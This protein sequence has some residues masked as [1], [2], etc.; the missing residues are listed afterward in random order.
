MHLQQLYW[1]SLHFLLFFPPSSWRINIFKPT[2][3]SSLISVMLS[4][5]VLCLLRLSI[6]RVKYSAEQSRDEPIQRE[7]GVFT[8]IN[9][10]GEADSGCLVDDE[11]SNPHLRLSTIELLSH[12]GIFH[13]IFH[14][15]RKACLSAT[16]LCLRGGECHWWPAPLS[17]V[18]Q[19]KRKC[20]FMCS[21]HLFGGKHL[22]AA[23]SELACHFQ[24]YKLPQRSL[25]QMC[26][27][28]REW[29]LNRRNTTR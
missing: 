20:L 19:T 5:P 23:H 4:Q 13:S 22:D 10:C 25:G 21:I 1:K 2:I 14:W 3:V 26:L 12:L 7:R 8:A 11:F 15:S 24:N 27:P 28:P 6:C 17:V 29:Q 9:E 18:N 16:S